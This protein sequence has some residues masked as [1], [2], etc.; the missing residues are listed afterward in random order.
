MNPT[1][2]PSSMADPV[3]DLNNYLQEIQK[4]TN[5]APL[6]QWSCVQ[7]GPNHQATH[8]GTYTFRNVVIGRGE[9]VT[10]NL[11]K[12]VAATQGLQYLHTNGIPPPA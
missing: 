8:I 6:L 7:N 1:T 5:L 4:P 11:A 2:D 10:I 3:R 9:G 12:S